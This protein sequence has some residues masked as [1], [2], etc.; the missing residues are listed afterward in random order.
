MTALF[1]FFFFFPPNLYSFEQV[2]AAA[3]GIRRNPKRPNSPC[4]ALFVATNGKI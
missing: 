2:V 1:S 4:S 3:E